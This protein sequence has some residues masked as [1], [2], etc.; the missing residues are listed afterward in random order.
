MAILLAGGASIGCGAR[1]DIG[2]A[3]E[4]PT[5][6]DAAVVDGGA[7]V[8]SGGDSALTT[9][10]SSDAG[11][12]PL[13]LAIDSTS[14]Y[15]TDNTNAVMKCP[16]AS[17]SEHRSVLASNQPMPDAI[18]IDA[19][20][21]YWVDFESQSVMK[22]ALSGC[23]DSPAA[24][25]TTKACGDVAVDAANVYWV[26]CDNSIV[27]CATAGCAGAPT[28]LVPSTPDDV[29]PPLRSLQVSSGFIY[30]TTSDEHIMRCASDNCEPTSVAVAQPGMIRIA[31]HG[32]DV[33][34]ST[35][36]GSIATLWRCSGGDCAMP[37]SITSFHGTNL[38]VDNFAI[39]GNDIYW[40][41]G[42]Q[43]GQAID[44]VVMGCSI[45]GCSA[46]T[47]I[48]DYQIY[49][50]SIAVDATNVYWTDPQSGVIA[51]APK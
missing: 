15:W 26:T 5:I 31:V 24:L 27:R 45:W 32:T 2:G 28:L 11:L 3:R 35:G 40:T 49:S 47:L 12:D 25:V 23:N 21:A 34:W 14:L 39:D 8:D 22:C 1:T 48:A 7:M 29:G 36:D 41:G 16:K 13:F 38:E 6:P 17:C 51:T 33:F 19:T 44:G 46:P 18:A 43:S 37:T 42:H 50:F 30:W 4:A 9:V 10:L 20:N